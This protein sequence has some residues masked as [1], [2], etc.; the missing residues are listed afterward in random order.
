MSRSVDPKT[1]AL[2]N[3]DIFNSISGV[4]HAMFFANLNMLIR[5]Y[6][7]QDAIRVPYHTEELALH[8]RARPSSGR[9][10]GLSVTMAKQ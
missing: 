9:L 3:G 2:K 7:A 5:V 4:G 8:I 1:T 6:W 10:S